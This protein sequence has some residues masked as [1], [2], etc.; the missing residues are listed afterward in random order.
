MTEHPNVA[1]VRSGYE[2]VGRGDIDAF[3]ALLDADVVWRE[4]TLTPAHTS[5]FTACAPA[6]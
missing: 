5:T 3:A 2:A 6:R 1:V 4:S